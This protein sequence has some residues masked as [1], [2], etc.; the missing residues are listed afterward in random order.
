MYSRNH[1]ILF[2]L[3]FGVLSFPCYGDPIASYRFTQKAIDRGDFI[4]SPVWDFLNPSTDYG[5]YQRADTFQEGYQI[6]LDP[7]EGVLLIA[8]Q[9]F[10][11]NQQTVVLTLEYSALRGGAQV[12]VI[13]LNSPNEYPDGQIGYLYE[14][15][16]ANDSTL[17]RLHLVYNPPAGQMMPGA[18]VWLSQDAT[19]SS[20][21]VLYSLN[22]YVF[23][24]VGTQDLV[25]VPNGQFDDPNQEL[26]VNINNDQGVVERDVSTSSLK[27][28][29]AGN[30]E[31]ANVFVQSEAGNASVAETLFFAGMDV[32]VTS[33]GQG[34][35]AL[36]MKNGSTYAG[37]FVNNTSLPSDQYT[38]VHI[39]AAID[40]KESM[41]Y[42]IGQNGG[43]TDPSEIQ[44][45]N[46]R[47]QTIS[48]DSVMGLEPVNTEAVPKTL[49]ASMMVPEKLSP[50]SQGSF[51]ITTL[52][53]E[54]HQPVSIP[55]QVSLANESGEIVLGSGFTSA[56]G[57]ST[58][59]FVLDSSSQP[60]NSGVHKLTV[61][62]NGL[63]I[64]QGDVTVNQNAVLLIETDKPIYKPGQIIQGRVLLLN[65]ALQPLTG[66]V[67][68]SI[69]DAKG[70]KIHKETLVTNDFGVASFDL[71]LANELNFGTWKLTAKSGAEI[72]HEMDIEVDRYVLP[73]FEVKLNLGKSWFLVDENVTGTIESRY[74]FGKPVKGKVH[75]EALRWVG[76]WDAYATADGQLGDG[77]FAFELPPVGYIA[78]TPGGEG[79]GTLQLKVVVTDETGHEESTDQIVQIVQAGVNIKLIPES[80]VIKPGLN[81]QMLVV[82]DTPGGSPLSLPVRL[83][84]DFVDEAGNDLGHIE[85]TVQTE[86]G[87]AT[88]QFD[89]PEKSIMALISAKTSLDGKNEE[90]ESILY[91]T[92]SPG[93]FYIHLR[94]KNE[95]IL[96]VGQQAVFEVLTT[97]GGTVFF[98][99][100]A[101]GRTLFSN[102]AEN[103]E[104]RFTVIPEM[105][106]G[107]RIVAYMI[108]P[109]N[110]VSADVLPFDVELAPTASLNVAF[111]A[112]EVK[113]GSP[114]SLS[115]NSDGRAMVGLAI[116]DES[117][118][119]L[120]EGRLNLRNVFAELER[121]FM[122]PQ[123]EVHED[124]NFRWNPQPLPSGKG[125]EDILKEN[126]LKVITTQNLVVPKAQTI[127]PW[128][129]FN[130][131]ILRNNFPPVFVD[132]LGPEDAAGG[133]GETGSY[134]EPDRVRTF[135][136]ETWLWKPDLLTGE[137]GSAILDLTAP[138]SITTWKLHA[139]STSDKGLGI[140]DG[141]IR[142]FQDFFAEPD[143]PYSVI[144]GDRFPL[145][146]RIFNY[147]DDEQTIRVTLEN[148]EGLGLQD[149]PVQEVS[150]AGQSAGSVTFT[151]QPDKVGMIP[152][153]IIAQSSQRADAIIKQLKV[154]PEGIRQEQVQNGVIKEATEITI[155]VR[156]PEPII[157]DPILPPN[158]R[159]EPIPFEEL[160]V[161]DSETLRVAVTA[162]LVGQSLQGLED[163]LGMPYGCGEQNMILLAPN[164]AV[165]R[166][167][168]N[169]GQLMP[170]IQAKAQYFITTG[171]QREL[172]YRRSEGSFSAFGEQDETGSLWLTAF[173]LS[174]F[175]D[176]REIQTIDEEVLSKAAEWIIGLQSDDGSWE[177][178]GFVIHQ[179][180]IGGQDGVLT[181]SAFVTNALLTYGGANAAAV[182]KAVGY[183]EQYAN[184]DSIDSYALAQIAYALTTAG[185][186]LAGQA[187]DTLLKQAIVDGSGIH[188]EP[189]SIETTAYAALSLIAHNRLEAQSALQWLTTQ[190][191]S[192]GGY[193]STQDTVVALKALTEAAAQ[194]SRNL[195]AQIEVIAAGETLHTFVLNEAN[196]DVL[197]TLELDPV[198]EIVLRMSGSGTVL[199]Q[200]AHAYHVPG[201]LK[202]ISDA[203]QLTVT[204]S[205]DHVAVDD[206]VDVNVKVEYFGMAEKTG[207]AIVDVSV[208]TGFAVVSESL[209]RVKSNELIKRIEQAGRKIIFYVDHFTVGEPLEFA[210]QVKALFPVKADSGASAAYLYYDQNTRAEA[211]GEKLEV[212]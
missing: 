163:L 60:V 103:N 200:V 204:Y 36:V 130:N 96:Q 94:Q 46:L 54:S 168:K 50:G 47:L 193:G 118:F 30:G 169:S 100:F 34:I 55:Y 142:V 29:T 178:Y 93:A 154:E 182:Q 61:K 185:S 192:L 77:A 81:Q 92:Y 44:I 181:L 64:M 165:L 80:P 38:S 109:N 121:I 112:E 23:E 176:A 125:T 187:L 73:S 83:V 115:V 33:A 62:S 139:V 85:E 1:F 17:R 179:E 42:V 183:L 148:A 87:L 102:T 120:V 190:R 194:Q 212:Q 140:A 206:I 72:Q 76:T 170:E 24:A 166:Y 68:L 114:V 63:T 14:T 202:P 191:N 39:G 7:G 184:D 110:E 16:P 31:A 144:R 128:K 6:S 49:A 180:M 131:P 188:W 189:H 160:I 137:D 21:I 199:Y 97:H 143:L 207:M 196:F 135:F 4:S 90:E 75:I 13:G 69:S 119:A 18:Q 127:D 56:K 22:I 129:L 10:S 164:I 141:Q 122:E 171:Y 74:F 210:F 101:N 205:A 95:G 67:E 15:S 86:N 105:S 41:F 203:M 70:I 133:R 9:P 99:V 59:T 113:P 71:P 197:Q 123:I 146:V 108:Q 3:L 25:T 162:S 11:T 175:S 149:E 159:P 19:G 8:K 32:R 198:D 53:L 37:I 48:V 174:T 82:T 51:S 136:P 158:E 91:A 52:D 211:G 107:S 5:L 98:D 155:P 177:P 57:F 153:S 186:S 126:H 116:V 28:K 45:D 167:L 43:S 138:D 132:V 26:T 161:P 152:V 151:L 79:N 145:V 117:V 40:P 20:D 66:D 58:Q 89:V 106:A 12:A 150:I 88:Y 201:H 195:N 147:I 172:T 209:E 104:I 35:T 208:P 27:L 111:N 134:Q 156:L 65:N 84:I 124:P 173:V 78:G 2:A 157:L